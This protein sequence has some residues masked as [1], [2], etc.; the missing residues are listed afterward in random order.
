MKQRKEISIRKI[1]GASVAKI[2]VFLSKEYLLLIIISNLIA[3]P[4]AYYFINLWLNNF[5]FRIHLNFFVFISAGIMT[6]L[7]TMAT[8]GYQVVKAARTN[9]V[10]ALKEE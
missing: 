10:D 4:V 3:F 9:P 2:A 7:I 5:T 1:F 6:L 8:I